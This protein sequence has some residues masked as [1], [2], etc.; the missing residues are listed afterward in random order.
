MKWLSPGLP[1]YLNTPG[2]MREGRPIQ[3][4]CGVFQRVEWAV[5]TSVRTPGWPPCHSCLP[6]PGAASLPPEHTAAHQLPWA[7]LTAMVGPFISLRL[8]HRTTHGGQRRRERSH[9]NIR[10][11]RQAFLPGLKQFMFRHSFYS[12]I[13]QQHPNHCC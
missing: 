4:Q 6:T 5:T 11:A 1:L 9:R 10:R 13:L 12:K 8:P 2:L 3:P 7:P